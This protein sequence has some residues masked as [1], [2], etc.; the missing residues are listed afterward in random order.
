M[1]LAQVVPAVVGEVEGFDLA[2]EQAKMSPDAAR[3]F[4]VFLGMPER[5]L[6]EVASHVGKR[7]DQVREWSVK[8]GWRDL[9]RRYDLAVSTGMMVQLRSTLI[10]EGFKSIQTVIGIRDNPRARDGDRLKA[11]FWVASLTGIGSQL[12]AEEG[13]MGGQ[14]SAD[15]LRRMATSGNPD[16]L[17]KLVELT[18]GRGE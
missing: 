8:Y 13:P 11:A 15:D 14:V 18:T 4:T 3:A 10:V 6:N 1:Q 17:R 16:D 2:H 5:K 7:D 9:A 12:A